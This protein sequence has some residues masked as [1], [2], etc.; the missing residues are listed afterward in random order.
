MILNERI[1]RKDSKA[2]LIFEGGPQTIK[3]IQK[4]LKISR[5][6]AFRR[7]QSLEKKGLIYSEWEIR[8]P[9]PRGGS[10]K[11]KRYYLFTKCYPVSCLKTHRSFI[12]NIRDS[13]DP[14]L[15]SW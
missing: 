1:T 5:S 14:P 12:S 7:L 13:N 15:K 8:K 10:S 11:I 6:S 2:L 4:K 3:E 9:E